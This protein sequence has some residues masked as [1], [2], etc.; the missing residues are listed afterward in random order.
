MTTENIQ[1]LRDLGEASKVRFKEPILDKYDIGC[2]LVAISDAHHVTTIKRNEDL[3]ISLD[4]SDT[5]PNT[6]LVHSD[7][8]PDTS[9]DCP[10]TFSEHMDITPNTFEDYP[11][12]KGIKLTNKQ[13]DIMNFCSVLRSS[14]EIL[15]I[16]GVKY[17]NSKKQRY[18]T[19]LV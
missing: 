15:E 9:S 14:R 12:T 18:I 11:N 13:K 19:E 1:K 3:D 4:D 10:N 6:F 7:A 17:H 5:T 8:T 16:A 2:E